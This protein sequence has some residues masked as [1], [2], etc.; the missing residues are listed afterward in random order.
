[1]H[2]GTC[3]DT[4]LPAG[5]DAYHAAFNMTMSL[6]GVDKYC[7][8]FNSDYEITVLTSAKRTKPVLNMPN[9]GLIRRDNSYLS[10]NILDCSSL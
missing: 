2:G 9:L 4:T 7:V 1:M 8:D 10:S 5:S 3:A 6:S